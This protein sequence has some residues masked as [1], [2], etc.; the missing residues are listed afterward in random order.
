[1]RE[2][3]GL[4]RCAV[5]RPLCTMHASVMDTASTADLRAKSRELRRSRACWA[6]GLGEELS[7]VDSGLSSVDTPGHLRSK[8]GSSFNVDVV[9]Y[10]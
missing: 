6:L 2:R 1:M 3:A 8:I 10:N 5:V 7:T 9:L 4:S